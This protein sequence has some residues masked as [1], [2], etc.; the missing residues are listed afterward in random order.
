VQPLRVT[1]EGWK[2]KGTTRSKYPAWAF[3]PELRARILGEYRMYVRRTP[4]SQI[5]SH[6]G[7]SEIQVYQDLQKA[8]AELFIRL[9][10]SILATTL[11][12]VEKRN[13]LIQEA[14][15]TIDELRTTPISTFRARAE[16][17]LFRVIGEQE[18]AIEE[19][20]RLRTKEQQ[21]ALEESS[22]RPVVLRIDLREQGT[23]TDTNHTGTLTNT[24]EGTII[25]SESQGFNVPPLGDF[26]ATAD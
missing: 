26:D 6:Y 10:D 4:V 12:Q 19:L 17:D 11:E 18:K 5:A 1:S 16:A 14:W 24:L 3:K 13:L 22:D 2:F 9:R 20:L 15:A 25:A 23:L 8:K 7:I 21:P